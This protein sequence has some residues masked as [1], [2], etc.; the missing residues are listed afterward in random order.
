MAATAFSIYNNAKRYLV[1]G[2]LDL[3][4]D[5]IIAHLF[6]SDSNASTFTLSL[7]SEVTGSVAGQ[8]GYPGSKTLTVAIT[9][10][11]LSTGVDSNDL[12]FTAS[13]SDLT[14]VQFLVIAESGGKLLCW[15]R[16]STA[17]FNVTSGNTL[18]V[19]I[20]AG[21]VFTMQ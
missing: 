20:A 5:T 9:D 4:T 16:L 2:T 18:T 13:G 21:G 10:T 8:A 14:S 19:T 3:D 7:L 6:K 15:T 1:D 11:G 12:V 17:L